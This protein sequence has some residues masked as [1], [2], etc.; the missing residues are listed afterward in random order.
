MFKSIQTKTMFFLLALAISLILIIGYLTVFAMDYA[1]EELKNNDLKDKATAV[2]FM[3]SEEV[4][5]GSS[6]DEKLLER[7]VS[8]DL[9]GNNFLINENGDTIGYNDKEKPYKLNKNQA[10]GIQ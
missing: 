5:Q 6:V 2:S 9:A 1:A 4:K 3:L 7:I 10:A 8:Q